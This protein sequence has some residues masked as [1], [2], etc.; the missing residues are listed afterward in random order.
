[1]IKTKPYNLTKEKYTNIVVKKRFK[2][3]WWLYLL[4]LLIS[5]FNFNKFGQDNFT[6]FTVIFGF[7]YPIIIFMY[8]YFWSR[9]K[10]HDTLFETM[11]M[12]FDNSNLY[13][14]RSGNET[15]IPSANIEKVI[16]EKD[17]WL[18]YLQQ[19]GSFIYIQKDIFYLKTDMNDFNNL[20]MIEE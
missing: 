1:M 9:S 10:N 3:S 15:K 18:L 14:E 7:T 16:S 20:L 6:T 5:I 13:F 17:F 8:L 12:S 19:K 4:M 11:N 2:K